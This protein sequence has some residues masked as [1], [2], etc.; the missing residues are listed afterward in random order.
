[1]MMINDYIY[2]LCTS[3]TTTSLTTTVATTT[4]NLLQKSKRKQ[5]ARIEGSHLK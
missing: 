2:T 1:M 5:N 3:V 4:T